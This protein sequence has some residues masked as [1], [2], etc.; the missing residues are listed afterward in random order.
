M[1]SERKRVFVGLSGGV[2]SSVAAALLQRQGYDVVGVFIK[3]WQP[4]FTECSWPEDRRSAMRV[5]ARLG[6]PFLTL[7]LSE[8]Y[9][10]NVLTYMIGEY[11]RGRT[12]NPDVACNRDIK[13]GAFLRSALAHGADLVATGHYARVRKSARGYELHA[14]TDGEKDQS[15]FLWTLSQKELAHI[16]FPI[17]RLKKPQVRALAGRMGLPTAKRPDS[18]GLCFVG[19][20]DLRDFLGRYIKGRRGR[21][22]DESGT[23]IGRHHGAPFYTIGQRHGFA[24]AVKGEK[25]EPH[26]VTAIDAERNT[27]TVSR[28]PARSAKTSPAVLLEDVHWIAGASRGELTARLRYRAPLLPVTVKGK[29]VVFRQPVLAP[30]GQSLVLYRDRECVGGGVIS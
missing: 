26:Y 11:R 14:G 2:D 24:T 15:Y 23:T 12:P 18:Q 1:K 10:R 8:E 28:Q 19:E 27:L 21:V 22:I 25:S 9:E 16:L 13:F 7:D 5:A 3:I 17:G 4:E 20:L 30:G 6:I 29:R